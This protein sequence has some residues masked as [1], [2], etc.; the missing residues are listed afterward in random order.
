MKSCGERTD[1]EHAKLNTSQA[2][3]S[4]LA[5]TFSF[6]S[7][8]VMLDLEVKV[9]VFVAPLRLL[10]SQTVLSFQS[11]LRQL[12]KSHRVA[13]CATGMEQMGLEICEPSEAGDWLSARRVET[14]G[15]RLEFAC[16]VTTYS[17]LSKSNGVLQSVLAKKTL[18]V[19]CLV[20]DEAHMVA[21]NNKSTWSKV[22]HFPA[23]IC[24]YATATPRAHPDNM[25]MSGNNWNGLGADGYDDVDGKRKEGEAKRNH[26]RS[27]KKK[28]PKDKYSQRDW[29][30]QNDASGVF[31][32]ALA[33]V[34][35]SKAVEKGMLVGS[36]LQL[37]VPW[38]RSEDREMLG[39]NEIIE[40]LLLEL[41]A[42][43]G[44]QE[45]NKF[46]LFNAPQTG[47]KE[48]NQEDAE[49]AALNAE[50]GEEEP[51][52]ASIQAKAA[53]SKV[54]G[55]RMLGAL[56][57]VLQ[58]I[59]I[60]RMTHVVSY[61][62]RVDRAKFVELVA[63]RLAT[64]L[65]DQWD[66]AGCPNYA[67][68]LRGLELGTVSYHNPQETRVTLERYRTASTGFVCNVGIMRMGQDIP[69]I[70]GVLFM[71]PV[72]AMIAAA[73]STG[74]ALRLYW[75]KSVA[76]IYLPVLADIAAI[77]EREPT[78][79][80]PSL[81]GEQDMDLNPDEELTQVEEAELEKRMLNAR[82]VQASYNVVKD[83]FEAMRKVNDSQLVGIINAMSSASGGKER[84]NLGFIRALSCA[85]AAASARILVDLGDNESGM[86]G[87]SNLAKLMSRYSCGILEF[88]WQESFRAVK[89]FIDANSGRWPRQHAKDPEEMR[90]TTWVSMQRRH[91]ERMQTANPA[92]YQQ[93]EQCGWWVWEVDKEE[94]WQETLQKV[95][96]FIDTNSGRWPSAGAKDPEEKRLGQ[97]VSQQRAKSEAMPTANPA[98]Y[99]QLEQCG[100]WVWDIMEEQ[101]QE[102][103]KAVKRF[104][105]NNKGNWPSQAAKDP[106]EKR[107]ATWVSTQRMSRESMPT[108]NPAKYQQLEE[109][110]WWK[111]K[112]KE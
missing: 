5:L 86:C 104:L 8:R 80:A 110:G 19:D 44:L 92:R 29:G 40:K 88:K 95:K 73:Q 32:P 55:G 89:Q 4:N 63:S 75:S 83:I 30:C 77:F 71:D 67:N 79:A 85:R 38:V 97:W 52:E 13:V 27:E 72:R 94:Q 112:A 99:Q 56:V 105:D 10:C 81:G 58:D 51:A 62:S 1:E 16:L 61:S 17:S 70:G 7:L 35:F 69:I 53:A 48:G 11:I 39:N 100:W 23:R 109:S 45:F 22:H 90:L 91:R 107:L 33:Q 42:E 14:N 98:R 37:L 25:G 93:L 64:L 31:G 57:T 46:E 6:T 102:S 18:F 50:A 101:W 74:R 20:A 106:E 21:S 78:T 43:Y 15:N 26:A 108:A 59:A 54:T 24:I 60:G 2:G 36:E 12:N 3:L 103:F 28:N 47:Q 76:V 82:G 87:R 9:A 111:W 41:E 49:A 34:S 84:S 68:R 65:A 96:Q 66:E